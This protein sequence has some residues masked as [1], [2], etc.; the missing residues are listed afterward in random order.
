MR[1]GLVLMLVVAV[2][3]SGQAEPPAILDAEELRAVIVEG[4]GDT[5]EVWIALPANVVADSVEVQLAGRVV[6]VRA[7]D[8][9]GRVLRS[10]PLQLREAVVEDGA[11]A[12]SAGPWLV[13]ELH[14]DL[15][16]PPF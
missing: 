11:T 13:V 8:D 9:A 1:L 4:D 3:G 14:K 2:V 5:V 6:A 10:R 16:P 7:R 12:H 15:T